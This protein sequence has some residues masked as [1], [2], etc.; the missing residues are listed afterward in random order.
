[1]RIVDAKGKPCPQPVIMA[2]DAMKGMTEGELAVLVDNEIAVQNLMKLG[3]H[4]GLETVAEKVSDEEYR[5]IFKVREQGED[6]K[7]ETGVLS[8]EGVADMPEVS[9]GVDARRKG[10]VVVISSEC[11]GSGDDELGRLLMKGFLYAQTQLEALPETVLLYNGGAK[12]AVEGAQTVEDL[13]SLE[14][15]GVQILTCGTCLNFYGLSEKLAVGSVTNM[16]DI[17]EKLAG[18]GSVVRP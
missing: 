5:V 13:K 10:T 12:L 18:A 8:A 14:A 4:S 16:Y 1:M 3:D 11:M 15:L 7:A 2:K 17:A 9:C 6:G